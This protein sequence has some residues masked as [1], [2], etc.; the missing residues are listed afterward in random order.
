MAGWGLAPWGTE[1]WGGESAGGGPPPPDLAIR[2]FLPPVVR[3]YPPKGHPNY[4][5]ALK[6]KD[7]HHVGVEVVVGGI[8]YRGGIWNG[9]LSFAEYEALLAAGYGSRIVTVA[10]AAE[11]PPGLD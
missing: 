9:P 4:Y 10:E 6:L 1:I 11:L 3:R 2:Y 7:W 8:T 5:T